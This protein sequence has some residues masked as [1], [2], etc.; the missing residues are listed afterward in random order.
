MDYSFFRIALSGVVEFLI[1][2]G[3]LVPA[4]AVTE[5][6]SF[7]GQFVLDSKPDEFPHYLGFVLHQ[8]VVNEERKPQSRR[9]QNEQE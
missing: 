5:I 3:K 1:R 6:C 7:R 9:K 2:S 4:N 8:R